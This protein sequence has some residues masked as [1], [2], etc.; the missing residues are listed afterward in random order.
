MR[1]ERATRER[2]DM[3]AY[4]L[5]RKRKNGTLGPLFIDARLRMP[6]GEWMEAGCHPTKGFKVRPG[7]H[8]CAKPIAPHLSKKG[9]VWVI[10][11][12][13]DYEIIQRPEA[14]GGQWFIAKNM[15]ILK[16][17]DNV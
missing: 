3:I 11:L 1:G 8:T 12:I 7:W 14:Q 6:I 16:E 9:R 5:V 15:L 13:V 10:V 17:M 2:T 4:K